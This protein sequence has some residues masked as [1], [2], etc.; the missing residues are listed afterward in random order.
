VPNPLAEAA[1]L[2]MV[3]LFLCTLGAHPSPSMYGFCSG[4]K[5]RD[6]GKR[7]EHLQETS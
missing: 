4:E 5:G 1:T 7:E 6:E 2:P 3:P